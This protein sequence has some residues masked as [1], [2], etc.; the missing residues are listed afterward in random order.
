VAS[1]QAPGRT[2]RRRGLD[3]YEAPLG[4]VRADDGRDRPRRR[5]AP[6][7][8][9]AGRRRRPAAPPLR[10]LAPPTAATV[11]PVSHAPFR[12]G[13]PRRVV[14]SGARRGSCAR[15]RQA[16]PIAAS[17]LGTR[18]SGVGG[19]NTP[20][21]TR[22]PSIALPTDVNTVEIRA[23]DRA[24]RLTNLRKVFW[25][26]CG[27]TK[28][29][30]LQYYADVAPVLLPHLRDGAMVMKRYPNRAATRSS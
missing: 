14:A 21:R 19:R 23:G 10:A 22:V 30:L 11:R 12:R 3:C 26:D 8:A 25:P 7:P 29:D 9:P 15:L 1:H 20:G 27:L 17:R 5:R 4:R 6:A 24:V 18:A 13:R 16:P 2:C 28:R